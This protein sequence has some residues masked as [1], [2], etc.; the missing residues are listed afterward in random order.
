MDSDNGAQDTTRRKRLAERLQGLFSP[1]T[2]QNL[3]ALAFFDQ[4]NDSAVAVASSAH[5][6]P[7]RSP[8]PIIREIACDHLSYISSREG[9]ETLATAL[10]PVA[11]DHQPREWESGGQ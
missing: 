9:L 8:A 5:I 11:Q 10:A 6:P 1:E 4:A 7:G 3:A 2:R